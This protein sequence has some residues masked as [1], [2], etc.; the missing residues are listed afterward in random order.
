MEVSRSAIKQLPSV[1]ER[2]GKGPKTKLK[3]KPNCKGPKERKGKES[4]DA[5]EA[6]G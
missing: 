6:I 3:P 2:L 4:S 5:V 1:A